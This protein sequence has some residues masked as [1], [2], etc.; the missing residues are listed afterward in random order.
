MASIGVF[1]AVIAI[2]GVVYV[3]LALPALDKMQVLQPRLFKFLLLL[4]WASF[5]GCALAA[6]CIALVA[7]LLSYYRTVDSE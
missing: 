7:I 2:G 4:F 3:Q 6:A 1:A 5:V